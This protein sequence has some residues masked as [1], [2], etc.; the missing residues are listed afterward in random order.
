M[1]V[2]GIELNDEGKPAW[3]RFGMLRL[4]HY[5][6]DVRQAEGRAMPIWARRFRSLRFM[7][8]V[9]YFQAC[10]WKLDRAAG[11]VDRCRVAIQRWV[12][13]E[14]RG[15]AKKVSV[16]DPDFAA[17]HAAIADLPI[18]LDVML[19]YLRM[20]ADA[21]AQLVPYLYENEGDIKRRSFRDQMVWFTRTRPQFDAE[22]ARVLGE[23]LGWFQALAGKEP[24]GLRD[25]VVHRGGTYQ[26]GW[27]VPDEATAFE[28]RASLLNS[29][30]FVE[31]NLLTAVRAIT[32]GWCAFLD[33][34]WHHFVNKLSV[35]LTTMNVHEHTKT[36][37]VHCGGLELPSFW[38]YPRAAGH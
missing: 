35:V 31:E 8:G 33:A 18:Y 22:Y 26:L 4:M 15:E 1:L 13:R 16:S 32:S 27:T 23:N 9:S 21:Y 34:A 19:F 17:Q 20:Q 3:F 30:G 7:H 12:E 24:S 25:V 2:H 37:Y 28:L 10:F 14:R 36:R 6:L 29:A 38:V 11:H 5:L